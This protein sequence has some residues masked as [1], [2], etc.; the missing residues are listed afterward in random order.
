SQI[1][2]PSCSI[3][4]EKV[5]SA[6]FGSKD[7]ITTTTLR[8][9]L[10]QNI[11]PVLPKHR[12]YYKFYEDDSPPTCSELF[13]KKLVFSSSSS[14]PDVLTSPEEKNLTQNTSNNSLTEQISSHDSPNSI[15]KEN[16]SPNQSQLDLSCFAISPV[17]PSKE[18]QT[19]SEIEPLTILRN[20]LLMNIPPPPPP[21]P[22][23]SRLLQRELF[24]D[25]N[26]IAEEDL[27]SEELSFNASSEQLTTEDERDS[28]NAP[29]ADT[30]TTELTKAQQ[31]LPTDKLSPNSNTSSEDSNSTEYARMHPDDLSD[32]TCY[33]CC[34]KCFRYVLHAM[35]D[36]KLE[37]IVE[38]NF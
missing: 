26:V 25:S 21:P 17:K 4:P 22:Q 23:S 2:P 29:D 24:A 13:P 20:Y 9:L 15:S 7:N 30:L 19:Q 37:F 28:L 14:S 35:E 18:N 27:D 36:F 5:L 33:Y 3:I 38:K 12:V 8:D 11:T 6:D 10:R 31:Q 32:L 34:S 16:F 1:F